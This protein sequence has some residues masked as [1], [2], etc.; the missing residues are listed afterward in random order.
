MTLPPPPASL[1][2]SGGTAAGTSAGGGSSSIWAQQST[3]KPEE[4]AEARSSGASS[5]GCY[6]PTLSAQGTRARRFG[7][8]RGGCGAETRP[9]LGLYLDALCSGG[10]GLRS[11]E[12]APGL[13]RR[14]RTVGR[15]ARRGQDV[16]SHAAPAARLALLRE[17]SLPLSPE[18]DTDSSRAP[19]LRG[20][21]RPRPTPSTPRSPPA[22][23][24]SLSSCTRSGTERCIPSPEAG[25]KEG[26]W[27]GLSLCLGQDSHLSCCKECLAA[28]AEMPPLN[29]F[30]CQTAKL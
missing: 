22:G 17:R 27:G 16:L 7:E 14:G 8:G 19:S 1:G 10:A 2:S 29:N 6:C 24:P 3:Q 23:V 9:R 4:G 21:P 11:A 18:P 15:R 13:R 5:G 30:H 26:T 28:P 20:S 12:A 25:G